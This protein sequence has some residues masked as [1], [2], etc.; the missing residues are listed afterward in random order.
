MLS[1]VIQHRPKK[2]RTFYRTSESDFSTF[3][4]ILVVSWPVSVP[5]SYHQLVY[6]RHAE[7]RLLLIHMAL[8]H[9]LFVCC[10]VH[11]DYTS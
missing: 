4:A 3:V 2:Y 11:V 5:P 6:G 10:E 1:T 8:L 7:Y 9:Y